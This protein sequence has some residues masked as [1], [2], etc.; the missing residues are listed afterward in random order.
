[1]SIIGTLLFY[2]DFYGSQTHLQVLPHYLRKARFCHLLTNHFFLFWA[3][4][5]PLCSYMV[6]FAPMGTIFV[7]KT[8]QI[9]FG[10]FLYWIVTKNIWERVKHENWYGVPNKFRTNNT[11]QNNRGFLETDKRYRFFFGGIFSYGS[12]LPTASW[13][14]ST[15]P[16]I[17]QRN[18]SWNS[19]RHYSGWEVEGHLGT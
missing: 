9:F 14:V 19:C 15:D 16:L 10:L 8:C 18:Y 6:K 12:V 17:C 13:V 4:T 2:H 11:Q 5:R 1:M 3:M 7:T